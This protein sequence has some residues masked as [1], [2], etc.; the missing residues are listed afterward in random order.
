MP[1]GGSYYLGFLEQTAR[2]PEHS[3]GEVSHPLSSLGQASLPLRGSR[4]T[5]GLSRPRAG[6]RGRTLDPRHTQPEKQLWGLGLCAASQ[7]SA[8]QKPPDRKPAQGGRTPGSPRPFS[9]WGAQG[10][11]SGLRR[12]SRLLGLP[13]ILSFSVR[14]WGL[15]PALTPAPLL[16]FTGTS[17]IPAT[18]PSPGP[19]APP[20]SAPSVPRQ[21]H[22]PSGPNRLHHLSC[23]PQ[24]RADLFILFGSQAPGCLEVGLP[25]PLLRLLADTPGSPI[26]P[27]PRGQECGQE[28]GLGGWGLRG[29]GARGAVG[30]GLS[31][32]TCRESGGTRLSLHVTSPS[33]RRHCGGGPGSGP[34]WTHIWWHVL[35]AWSGSAMPAGPGP[36]WLRGGAH[37]GETGPC[38][39]SADLP[40]VTREAVSGGR[41]GSFGI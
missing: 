10:R 11:L 7:P 32:V 14:A 25:E 12:N 35:R 36:M 41:G 19:T 8:P 22:E 24:S 33:L 28:Q 15:A 13:M 1:A 20:L 6:G 39:G 18:S 9:H 5:G 29:G 2:P 3:L 17:E 26:L 30:S 31:H 4:R 37:G 21:G 40:Q 23:W 38:G 27:P 16:H 34:A